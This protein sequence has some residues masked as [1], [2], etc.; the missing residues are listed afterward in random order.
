MY[1]SSFE[2]SLASGKFTVT[3]EITPPASASRERM[4]ELAKLIKGS[5]TAVN[6]TD[7]PM[8][9]VRLCSL[10]G[11]AIALAE[12][13]EPILQIT[14][15]DR[16]RIALS[17]EVLG[18]YALGV[19]NILA[20][21]GDR[22]NVDGEIPVAGDLDTPGELR[23]ISELRRGKDVYGNEIE[24][25]TDLFA[26]TVANPFVGDLR[27]N[28]AMMIDRLS[29]GAEFIQTQAVYDV[30]RFKIWLK[31]MRSAGV[32]APILPGVIPLK[33]HRSAIYMRD[34]IPGI[35]I[36]DAFIERLDKAQDQREEGLKIAEEIVSAL[37]S[38]RGIQGV[39]IMTVRWTG[40]I[41]ELVKRCKLK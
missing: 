27:T 30:E 13:L 5:V 17:D 41:P 25:P 3:G 8:G 15:R 6:I 14:C 28:V 39:H 19:R 23:L 34:N 4:V 22:R 33:S 16:N 32:K 2:R 40:A 26:G 24:P 37:V 29:A 31:A 36:P 9:S 35:M 18:G 21:R 7:S 20:L 1:R 38:N 11:A 10:A 12:G